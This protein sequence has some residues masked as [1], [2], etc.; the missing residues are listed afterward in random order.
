MLRYIFIAI[1]IIILLSYSILRYLH[2]WKRGRASVKIYYGIHIVSLVLCGIIFLWPVGLAFD[3]ILFAGHLYVDVYSSI[4]LLTP[5]FCF[6]RGIVRFL[7]KRFQ[8]TGKG[9]RFFNHPSKMIILILI[10]TALIGLY[11]FGNEKYIR[12]TEYTVVLDKEAQKEEISVILVSDLRVGGSMTQWE[13][14]RLVEKINEQQ[15]DLILFCGNLIDKRASDEIFEKTLERLAGLSASEGIYIVGGSEDFSIL[16]ESADRLEQKGIHLLL[17][18]SVS[19]SCGVQLVGC[20]DRS[21]RLKKPLDYVTSLLNPNKPSILLS[22]ERVDDPV[23]Q[24]KRVDYV[25]SGAKWGQYETY[26]NSTTHFLSTSGLSSRLPGKY[27]VPSEI[28]CIT[29]QF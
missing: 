25:L 11:G 9:Y 1:L 26:K 8:W 10:A 23:L 3:P 24:E 5:L 16:S 15:P 4:M 7:G 22:H 12:N 13:L 27:V 14:S 2:L 18:K 19:L 21:D 20:R 28:V 29:L 6:L 17:D